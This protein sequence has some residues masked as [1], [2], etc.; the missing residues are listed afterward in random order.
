MVKPVLRVFYHKFKH[1]KQI[2][3]RDVHSPCHACFLEMTLKLSSWYGARKTHAADLRKDFW[4]QYRI[5]DVLET[6]RQGNY[7]PN[8]KKGQSSEQTRHRREHVD[9]NEAH[10][11]VFNAVSRERKAN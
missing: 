6:Q 4:L 1:K 3:C 7:Q 9:S 5:E 2:S 10:I 11:E 8:H